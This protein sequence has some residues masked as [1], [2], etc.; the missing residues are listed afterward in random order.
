M[1]SA[2]STSVCAPRDEKN[3]KTDAIGELRGD[4]T[5]PPEFISFAEEIADDERD[6]CG[7]HAHG[8]QI[9][10]HGERK[11]SGLEVHDGIDQQK[12][13]R[14]RCGGVVN[15]VRAQTF[16]GR[17]L[18]DEVQGKDGCGSDPI[19]DFLIVCPVEPS[20]CLVHEIESQD[21]SDS[22]DASNK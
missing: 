21:I 2:G 1:G 19:F 12:D 13:H 18:E 8:G 7:K 17:K 6:G 14:D 11:F 3:H 9:L 10:R 4:K 20:E 16:P 5:V 22:S 15:D